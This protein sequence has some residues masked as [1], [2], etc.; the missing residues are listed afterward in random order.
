MIKRLILILFSLIAI[1]TFGQINS[2]NPTRPFGSNTIYEFGL[3]PSNLPSS[4]IYGQSSEVAVLYETWKT[5]YVENC[6]TDKARVKF[7]N[8]AQTVS[9][10]IGYGMLLS[11]YAGDKPLFDKLWA[12]YKN[13]RNGNGV[14]H[15]RIEGCGANVSGQNGATDAELDA[16]MALIVASFQWPSSSTP[17]NYI[18]DGKALINAIKN[19]ETAADGTF[20]NGDSWKPD[21][22]NPSYQA[23]AYA[24]AFKRFMADNG[25]NQNAFWDNVAKGTENLFKNN[26]HISSGL[27]TNWCTPAGPPSA[28]CSGSGT[29]PDKFGYDACRA[30]WRQGVDV[31]WWGKDST[32]SVQSIVN[33]Q[34]DFWINKGGATTI[35]GNNN[36]NHDG[37]G[38]GVHNGAFVGPVGAMSL[39]C[40]NTP[41]HQKFVDDIYLQLR[42]VNNIT[43]LEGDRY[44]TAI[45]QI[46]GLFVQT[47]NFWNPYAQVRNS[48]PIVSVQSPTNNASVCLSNILVSVNATDTD[49]SVTKVELYAGNNLIATK[50]EAPFTFSW[51]PA[52]SGNYILKAVAYDNDLEFKESAGISITIKEPSVAATVSKT[53]YT[54]CKGSLATSLSATG[55]NIKWYLANLELSS[56]TPIPETNIA[57]IKNYYVTQNTNGCE[58]SKTLVSVEIIETT[59]PKVENVYYCID[60]S[61]TLL[62]ATGTN[63]KWYA[64]NTTTSF[65]SSAPKP[66]SNQNSL[67]KYYVSQTANTCE[68]DRAEISVVVGPKSTVPVVTSPIQICQNAPTLPITTNGENIKWYSAAIGGNPLNSAPSPSTAAVKNFT[69]YV[70]Q[71]T[72]GCESDRVQIVAQINALPNAPVVASPLN[73]ALNQE[74]SFLSANG[75]NL[76]WYSKESDSIGSTNSPLPITIK[77]GSISYFVSQTVNTCLSPKAELKVV[78][79]TVLSAGKTSLAPVIDGTIDKVWTK[80]VAVPFTKLISGS[81]SNSSDLSGSFKLLWDANYLYV[82]G[83]V[84]D[85]LKVNDSGD[86]YQD[87][88]I[89]LFFDFKNK[90][91]TTYGANDVQYTFGFGDTIPAA[92]NNKSIIGVNFNFKANTQGYVFEARIPWA[93][94]GGVAAIGDLHGFDFEVN[95][96]DDGGDRDGKM[97]WAASSDNTWQ[98]PSLMGII[99]LTGSITICDKPQ[100]P[101]ITSTLIETCS[102]DSILLSS[103]AANSSGNL[104]QWFKNG[105]TVP[106]GNLKNLY[107]AS[108]GEYFVKYADSEINNPKCYTL[109]DKK[110]ITFHPK[111]SLPE[112][113][114]APKVCIYSPIE[115]YSYSVKTKNPSVYNWSLKNAKI[116]SGNYTS[117]IVVEFSR[118]QAINTTLKLVETNAK[119][120]SSDTLIFLIGFDCPNALEDLSS[121]NIKS[122]KVFPNPFGDILNVG[123][124]DFFEIYNTQGII[125]LSGEIKNQQINTSLLL[126]NIYILKLVGETGQEVLIISKE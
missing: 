71:R 11:A 22:R 6:G 112:I 105:T 58:S 48:L 124:Y 97:S 98:N 4:G 123:L 70:S 113:V 32:R 44:F 86:S 57:G 77:E 78:V 42:D 96:D 122:S 72:T 30:P 121:K 73:Y 87:D 89:E 52:V 114:G 93:N 95:D 91:A 55:Q 109:S 23:P 49:G 20:F 102:G 47:G 51:L 12:Y 81:V 83:E 35:Q 14:M 33:R 5:T 82:L 108:T 13:Y 125:Q 17:H 117:D 31:L 80:V 107:V 19:T 53:N 69:Y 34:A 43:D 79:S 100:I 15:W 92:N 63:L 115:I 75:S 24:R 106:S 119:N 7:D 67:V 74:A 62:T 59:K 2:N 28:S 120:C 29:A 36:V 111:P 27:S 16:A 103:N 37:T 99:Q 21:C 61:T 94:L 9:E 1:Q 104:V 40:S 90:K 110:I 56:S 76:I 54:Y 39:A 64:N 68:S 10:G 38:E 65:S 25:S 84:N 3:I 118:T 46:M 101:T 60:E 116:L 8:P 18:T 45:L 26:A 126:K 85:N 88:A 66:I 50:V 41:E